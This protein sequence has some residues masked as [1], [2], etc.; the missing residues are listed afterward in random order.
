MW[1]NFFT[2]RSYYSSLFFKSTAIICQQAWS[3]LLKTELVLSNDFFSTIIRDHAR[4]APSC[5]VCIIPE[6]WKC[7]TDRTWNFFF[8]DWESNYN[9]FYSEYARFNV[10]RFTYNKKIMQNRNLKQNLFIIILLIIVF[11]DLL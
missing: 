6:T 3:W 5:C 8:R 1:Q 11:L 4:F 7:L 9:N 2:Y 10:G